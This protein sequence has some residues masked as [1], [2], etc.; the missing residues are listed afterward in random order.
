MY[1]MAATVAPYSR[2][3][4]IRGQQCAEAPLGP[5]GATKQLHGSARAI[6]RWK[7]ASPPSLHGLRGT[8]GAVH[9]NTVWAS[10]RAVARRGG[11]G[12]PAAGRAFVTLSVSSASVRR[13][14]S[15]ASDQCPRVPVQACLSRRP[16]SSV[17]CGRLSVQVSAV[18]C[19]VSGVRAFPRPLCPA[20]VR[21]CSAAVGQAAARLGWP[22][23]AWSPAASTTGSWS[24]RV[25]AWR[26][27]LAQAVLGQQRCRFGLG[28]RRGGGWAV[29]RS[30]AW[31]TVHTRARGSFVGKEPGAQRG[32]P[33]AASCSARDT[34]TIAQSSPR[35]VH[36]P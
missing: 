6:S 3:E 31:P 8:A 28:R 1:R 34:W 22:G 7:V 24:A 29:A 9:R 2:P 5:G 17:R 15:G 14:V 27:K 36:L 23:S 12:G 4:I 11:P 16:V 20:E 18:R 26:S 33:P 32:S 19:P 13:P 21:S 25:G 10:Q 30:T 35:I